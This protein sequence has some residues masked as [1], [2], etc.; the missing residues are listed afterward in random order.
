MDVAGSE[1]AK[2]K[3]AARKNEHK[4]RKIAMQ[5][6][7]DA[8]KAKF[9]AKLAKKAEERKELIAKNVEAYRARKAAEKAK[10]HKHD[11]VPCS[12]C[13]CRGF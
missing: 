13:T 3:A 7:R 8:E 10:L 6:E 11:E 4:E 12:P 1:E 5:E 2:Q 9:K